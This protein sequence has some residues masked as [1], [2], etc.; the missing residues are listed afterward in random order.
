MNK[1]LYDKHTRRLNAAGAVG[2]ALK[3]KVI[4]SAVDIYKDATKNQVYRGDLN[5]HPRPL[6]YSL[7]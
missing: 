7:F 2:G 4:R 6:T 1:E 3:I 5:F